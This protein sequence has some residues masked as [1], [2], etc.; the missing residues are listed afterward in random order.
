MVKDAFGILLEDLGRMLHIQDLQPD[1]H[2]SCKIHFAN[3]TEGTLEI[4]DAR[5]VLIIAFDLGNPS[6]GKYRENLFCEALKANGASYPRGGNFA[7]SSRSE[8]LFL[9]EELPMQD[10]NADRIF[11]C[12]TP[13]KE[14]AKKWQDAITHGEIPPQEFAERSASGMFGLK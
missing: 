4:D 2:N 14:K 13:M 1:R 11:Q 6:P 9:T 7:F 3:G 5:Q 8:R 10:I 12:L